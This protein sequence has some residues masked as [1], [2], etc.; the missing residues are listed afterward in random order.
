MPADLWGRL[1]FHTAQ[2]GVIAWERGRPARTLSMQTP[3]GQ[4]LAD[5][6]QP[7]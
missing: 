3:P 1:Q 5:R 7:A 6:T 2:P 4:S